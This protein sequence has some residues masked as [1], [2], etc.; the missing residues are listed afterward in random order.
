VI[1]MLAANLVNVFMARTPA[2]LRHNEGDVLRPFD[3]PAPVFQ[4]LIGV[5][6]VLFLRRRRALGRTP[7]AARLDAVRRFTLLIGLGVLLDTVGIF[8]IG[9]RWGVLQTLGLGG[10]VATLVSPLSDAIVAAIALFVLGVFS[11]VGHGEVHSGPGSA[12]AFVPLTLAG[13]LVGRALEEPQPLRAFIGRSVLVAIASLSVAIAIHGLGIPFNKLLGSSSFV[14]L[15][16]AV[17]AGLAG[18][19]AALEDVGVPLPAWLAAVGQN[20]LTAWVLQYVLVFYPAWL[21]FPGWHRLSIGPGLVAITLTIATLSAL[22]VAL[23]RRGIR[24]P[25]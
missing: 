2:V 18:G 1:A 10:I 24:I 19:T 20:A 15:A 9:L 25:L 23:G 7:G 8:G 16:T 21:A 13:L 6:L 4:F 14:A 11:G 22:S 5:S 12:L 3:L 17:S